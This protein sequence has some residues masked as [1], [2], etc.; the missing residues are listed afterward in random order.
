[1]YR[2][3]GRHLHVLEL[4]LDRR[5]NTATL[6][7]ILGDRNVHDAGVCEPGRDVIHVSDC[8]RP[9]SLGFG[10]LPSK[11]SEGVE[12]LLWLVDG[13]RLA[14]VL[15]QCVLFGRHDDSGSHHLE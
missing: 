3:M 4:C 9:I 12:L 6:L 8:G 11:V 1:M 13:S 2:F 15:G 10:I 14:G 7:G 5:W